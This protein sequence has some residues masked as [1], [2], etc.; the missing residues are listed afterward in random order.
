MLWML[1]EL[2]LETGLWLTGKTIKGVYNLSY[3]CIYGN[4]ICKNE[5]L[6]DE[7]ILEQ[8]KEL[9]QLNENLISQIEQKNNK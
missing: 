6:S 9:K 8:L 3:Y 2:I 4:G 5:K 7:K 1:T